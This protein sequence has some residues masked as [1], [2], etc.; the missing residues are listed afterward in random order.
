VRNGCLGCGKT[1]EAQEN[2]LERYSE[3]G[4]KVL[5]WT[6]AHAMVEIS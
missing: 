6:D 1:S 5:V 2:L 3:N 4:Y